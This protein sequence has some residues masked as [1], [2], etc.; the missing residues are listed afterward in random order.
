MVW[1]APSARKSL[2]KKGYSTPFTHR[3][4]VF[5]P[6]RGVVLL[7]CMARIGRLWRR[8]VEKS[9]RVKTIVLDIVSIVLAY[10]HIASSVFKVLRP[11]V[12]HPVFFMLISDTEN[13]SLMVLYYASHWYRLCIEN[14]IGFVFLWFVS[15]R[16][17]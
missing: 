2:A 3:T 12:W 1:K 13:K 11:A 15:H 5:R 8:L 17:R 7:W 10:V 4:P 16:F 6:K 9:S 14:R